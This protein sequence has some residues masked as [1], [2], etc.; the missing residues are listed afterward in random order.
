MWPSGKAP[1][2]GPG[3]RGFESL[4]PSQIR[5]TLPVIDKLESLD[6]EN[7][8][9]TGLVF[10]II[11][12][13]FVTIDGYITHIVGDTQQLDYDLFNSTLTKVIKSETLLSSQPFRT[14]CRV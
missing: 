7:D 3:I 4:R 8:S 10:L 11:F 2:F 12:L 9:V 5:K 6:S 1:G 14:I 13:I